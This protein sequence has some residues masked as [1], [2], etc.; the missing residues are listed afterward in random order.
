MPKSKVNS[1]LKNRDSFIFSNRDYVPISIQ[2]I[3][4][5]ESSEEMKV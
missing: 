4:E 3:E 5:D 1:P 2:L